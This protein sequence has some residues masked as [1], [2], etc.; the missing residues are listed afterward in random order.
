MTYIVAHSLEQALDILVA[1]RATVLAGGTDLFAQHRQDLPGRTI[2]DLSELDAFQ[3]ISEDRNGWRIGANVTWAELLKTPLLP[4][5]D[6]LKSA[7][8]ELGSLQIQSSATLVGNLCN[9]SPAADGVPALLTL[10][11]DVELVS[12]KGS[13]RV[14]LETFLIGPG[15]TCLEPEELVSAI[16]IPR[17]DEGLT[18]AFEKLGSRRYLVISIAMVAVVIGLNASGKI[19]TL[20]MAIGACGPV[21]QRQPRLETALV[22]QNPCDVILRP[23]DLQD[24]SP[25]TDMRATA[26]Y[27][28]LAAAELATRVIRQGAKR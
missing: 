10:N 15:Q 1:E 14:A 27:R 2:L 18:A 22:G 20:R 23:E 7:G 4:A 5:F 26:Q 3:G 28:R 19:E 9:A 24:L 6:G 13:R 12:H 21:A 16:H 11:A 25:I 17:L 8:R